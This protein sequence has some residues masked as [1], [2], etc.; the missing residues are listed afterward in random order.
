MP[1]YAALNLVY[2]DILTAPRAATLETQVDL[3]RERARPR[4]G[5]PDVGTTS[6]DWVDLPGA[7]IARIVGAV[8][9]HLHAMGYVSGGTGSIRVYDV[10]AAA[11]VADSTLTFTD[12]TPTLQESGDL[13]LTAAHDYKA[14]VKISSAAQHAVVYG[15]CLVTQ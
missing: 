9:A 3:A 4:G 5:I 2:G 1:K 12:A 14:Q 6:T 13:E 7:I 15:A 8:T 11:V 10:T